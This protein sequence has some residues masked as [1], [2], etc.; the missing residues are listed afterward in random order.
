MK[1]IYYIFIF[2]ILASCS[3]IKQAE[4]SMN[5]G[6]YLKA[7]D[8]LIEEY[9][10]EV[11]EKKK[12][13]FLP[14]FQNA[15][16]KMVASQ[17]S[18]IEQLKSAKNPAYTEDIYN[19]LVGL[20]KRQEQ[21]R[22]FLPIYHKG[23]EMLFK[24]KN[25]LPAVDQAKNDYVAYLY[26]SSRKKL[27]SQNKQDIRNAHGELRKIQ[28]L[29][30][31]FRDVENLLEEAHYLGTDFVLIQIENRSNQLLPRR[32]E[33]DLT[34]I[35]TYG[36]NNFWTEYHQKKQNDYTY[37]YLIKM[38][39]EHIMVS[40]ERMNTRQHQF[41][42]EII[43]GWEFLYENGRKVLDSLGKPIKVDKIIL[44]SARVE[45]VIQEKDALVQG[46]VDLI[47]LSNNQIID[48]QKLHSEF[49]F[50]NHF[51]KFFGDRRALDD[52]MQ[53]L[54]YNQFIPFPSHEQMVF[55]SGEEIKAQ[56]KRL[57]KRRFK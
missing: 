4:K 54:S 13:R 42:R 49:G 28:Q 2:S 51:A 50:R 32:L 25:Y 39:I 31:G 55:D 9:Q 22:R 35:S 46:R 21:L 52:H 38:D 29:S 48:S 3:S 10:K 27:D 33:E 8:L 11:S 19:T 26:Q 1:H 56:L 23:K 12:E 5:S 34:Q 7:Y 36:L 57:L 41:E 44:V 18:R 20:H 30:P 37:D 17:E 24:T 14:M 40:P 16:M 47:D 45:E 15:Y 53:K 6:D 43:D